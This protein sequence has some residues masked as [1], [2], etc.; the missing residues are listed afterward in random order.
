MKKIILLLMLFVLS[1]CAPTKPPLEETQIVN[2]ESIIVP[3]DFDK[4]PK[5]N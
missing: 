3:P 2:G 5:E 4:L 1:A